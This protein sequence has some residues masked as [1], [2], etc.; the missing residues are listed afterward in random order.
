VTE[1]PAGANDTGWRRDGRR[2]WLTREAAYL[3]DHEDPRDIERW[4]AA[5]E[6]IA[7]A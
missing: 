5:T 7:C 2:L 1:L 4:P 6:R 3:V